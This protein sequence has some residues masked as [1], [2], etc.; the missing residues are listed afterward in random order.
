M[1]RIYNTVA[2]LALVT[3]ASAA[4]AFPITWQLTAFQ[5]NIPN[6]GR[7]NTITVHPSDSR[8]MIVASESGGLFRTGDEG[9]TWAHIDSLTPYA[10][11]AVA[12]VLTDPNI[13][14]ATASEGFL[15]QNAGGIWR[16]TD[17]GSTWAHIPDPPAP[18]G[19]SSRFSA[20]EISIAPDTGKIFIATSYGVS[21]S[22]D[23]GTTWTTSQP[24]PFSSANSVLALPGDLVLAGATW[25]GIKRSTDGGGTW[26]AATTAPTGVAD[27]HAFGRS[28][29]DG[30]HAYV[31]DQST[32]LYVTEDAGVTWTAIASAPIGNGGCGGIAFIKAL[33]R[34]FPRGSLQLYF[35][36]RCG[37]LR[38]SPPRIAGTTRFDYSGAWTALSLDHGDTRDLAF[39]RTGLIIRP[40]LLG[41]DGGLHRTTDG[42]NTWTF[43]GGGVNG[44]NALQITEVKGQW[45]DDISRYDLYFGTQDNN[46]LAST[47][48]GATWP[49]AICCEGFF[50]EMQ[51]HV[52]TAGDTQVT[53]V[54]CGACSNLR[55]GPA[56]AGTVGWSNPAGTVAGN[57]AIVSHSFHTQGVNSE[58]GFTAGFAMTWNLG[59]TLR[60]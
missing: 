37:L 35:G 4:Q 26:T 30:T 41:T 11:G 16:S 42:G 25:A 5:P 32:Q 49:N 3:L 60:R 50:F 28:P 9:I 8:V 46:N 54:S 34:F 12:Y 51:K 2:V 55:S 44:Y 36:N 7:A 43:T 39:K 58:A 21:I 52:A 27:M 59:G 47:D 33:R 38:L 29:F 53:Y 14:I 23:N 1:K 56:L 13:V 19:L 18:P 6:G 45:I 22:A 57:P 24:F 20:G 10:M 40:L 15:T 17:G 31:V 48:M